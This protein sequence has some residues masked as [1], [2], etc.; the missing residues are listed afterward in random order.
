M[1]R[2]IK[3]RAW[4]GT[5]L[6]T[7]P[8]QTIGSGSSAEIIEL[9]LCGFV[10]KRNAFGLDYFGVNP[11]F[12]EPEK[13]IIITQFTGLKDENEKDIYEGDIVS[14]GKYSGGS[15]LDG[16]PCIHI[17]EWDEEHAGFRTN[18]ILEQTHYSSIETFGAEIIG[19]IFQNPELLTK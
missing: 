15:D 14:Y 12:D 6:I 7:P 4:T 17:V 1:K 5:E 18:A 8:N 19:N 3:F 16:K 2:E 10:S 11:T 13:D 9:S